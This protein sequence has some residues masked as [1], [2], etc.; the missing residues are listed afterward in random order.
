MAQGKI[1][2]EQ[3]QHVARLARLELTVQEEERLQTELS[4]MLAYVDQLN[5]LD[6]AAI[7]PTAQVGE[8]GTPLRDDVVTNLP[9]AEEMLA[10]APARKGTFFKVP[11]IIE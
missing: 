11:Q 9:A 6:T 4:A 5:E 10:N 7:E 2:R 1:S 3:V 8:A